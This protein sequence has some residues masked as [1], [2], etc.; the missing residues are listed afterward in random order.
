[1]RIRQKT[2]RMAQFWPGFSREAQRRG[3][4]I[5]SPIVAEALHSPGRPLDPAV[6]AALEPRFGHDFSRVRI[7]TERRAA[8]SARGW[9]GSLLLRPLHEFNGD[10]YTWSGAKNGAGQGGPD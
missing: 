2:A 10:W 1:M 6:R 9:G 3:Q 8:E 4:D 7:H 5:A